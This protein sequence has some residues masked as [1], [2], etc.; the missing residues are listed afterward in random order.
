MSSTREKS[1]KLSP[2]QVTNS[3][4]APQNLIRLWSLAALLATVETSAWSVLY[5]TPISGFLIYR[6]LAIFHVPQRQ[7]KKK[8]T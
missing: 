6:K 4:L 2:W 7:S 3:L 1:P 5:W 8:F